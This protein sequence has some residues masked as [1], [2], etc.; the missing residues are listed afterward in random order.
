M[1]K[2]K[3]TCKLSLHQKAIVVQGTS[4]GSTQM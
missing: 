2:S 4:K 1:K 3:S